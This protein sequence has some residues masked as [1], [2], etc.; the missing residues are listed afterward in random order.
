VL[1]GLIGLDLEEL[2]NGFMTNSFNTSAVAEAGMLVMVSAAITIG[3]SKTE[4]TKLVSC[5]SF[6]QK[7]IDHQRNL[8]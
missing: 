5:D 4:I 1:S 7:E 3:D 2:V 8:T 6:F